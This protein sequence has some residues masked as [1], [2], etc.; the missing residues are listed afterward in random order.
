VAGAL[1]AA[2][3]VRLA[4]GRVLEREDVALD[5][6]EATARELGDGVRSV[7]PLWRDAA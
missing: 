7:I 3:L 1:H 2:V 4:D 5:A 6:L